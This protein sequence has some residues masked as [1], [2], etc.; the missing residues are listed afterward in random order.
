M[1]STGSGR[2][3]G[4]RT[5][6]DLV[7]MEGVVVTEVRQATQDEYVLESDGHL[8]S[9]IIRHPAS[10]SQIP[11]APMLEI[12]VGTHIR[13]S[14]ICILTDANP[15]NGEVPFN[16]LMRNVDDIAVVARP[17]WLNVRHLY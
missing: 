11:L 15:F 2:Q 17:P 13:V 6:F 16:I 3:H 10:S 8:L 1:A 5:L 9:A 7:S 4:P 12:P 14:G